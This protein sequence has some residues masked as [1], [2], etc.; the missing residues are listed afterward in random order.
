MNN[1]Q[2]GKQRE[3]TEK[4]I[5]VQPSY[6]CFL[7]ATKKKIYHQGLWGASLPAWSLH[8]VAFGS[9][10]NLQWPYIC[11][12][13]A[14]RGNH[15][16]RGVPKP[17][18]LGCK[19][20]ILMSYFLL[21][22]ISLLEGVSDPSVIRWMEEALFRSEATPIRFPHFRHSSFVLWRKKPQECLAIKLGKQLNSS[23]WLNRLSSME[24]NDM[25]PFLIDLPYLEPM[26]DVFRLD[27]FRFKS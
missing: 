1:D 18:E 6:L 25:I 14:S 23:T 7:L 8:R 15:R 3:G 9:I 27:E 2:E 26:V 20:R 10:I 19:E 13:D 24:K 11:S 16:T 5:S 12:R 4:R 21:L 22:E 17:A